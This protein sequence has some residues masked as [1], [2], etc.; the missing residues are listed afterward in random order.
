MVMGLR[1]IRSK[2]S[3]MKGKVPFLKM[4][5]Q[6]MLMLIQVQRRTDIAQEMQEQ[7]R[8]HYSYMTMVTAL[9]NL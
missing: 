1:Y 9:E 8:M 7:V 4:E 2:S 3:D 5:M 6:R